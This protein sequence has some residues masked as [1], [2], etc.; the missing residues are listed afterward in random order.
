MKSFAFAAIAA[1]AA[2]QDQP[3][4]GVY[5]AATNVWTVE[6]IGQ[7]AHDNFN[8]NDWTS[9]QG[10]ILDDETRIA[11]AQNMISNLVEAWRA[12]LSQLP[13]VCTPGLACRDE[14][15][16]DLMEKLTS[17][18]SQ[19][20]KNID[21]QFTGGVNFADKTREGLIVITDYCLFNYKC[22]I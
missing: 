6:E 10:Q 19:T 18:W 22:K 7:Y 9:F 15:F 11:F 21:T 16:N 17:L 2:A 5:D 14:K 8:G 12:S 4:A 3:T 20:L 1:A 13:S